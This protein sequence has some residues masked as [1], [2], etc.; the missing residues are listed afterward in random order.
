M[1]Q[2]SLDPVDI[3]YKEYLNSLYSK[4]YSNIIVEKISGRIK[5]S[6]FGITLGTAI[7]GGTGLGILADPR[8]A[9]ACGSVSALSVILST[10]K[11]AYQWPDKYKQ[12]I[13]MAQHYSGICARYRPLVHKLNREKKWSNSIGAA[14]KEIDE[15]NSKYVPLDYIKLPDERRQRIQQEIREREKPQT[16]WRP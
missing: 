6:D 3:L 2:L 9:V 1:L 13:E 5:H 7:S 4:E 8:F 11:A 10:I 15:D 12:A 16:W 14:F